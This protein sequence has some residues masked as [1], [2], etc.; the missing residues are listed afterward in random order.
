MIKD[1]GN[2]P[3]HGSYSHLY[4]HM[5]SYTRDTHIGYFEAKQRRR[6]GDLSQEGPKPFV[7][8]TGRIPNEWEERHVP[9]NPTPGT[10]MEYQERHVPIRYIPDT[11]G[12]MPQSS[13]DRPRHESHGQDKEEVMSNTNKKDATDKAAATDTEDKAKPQVEIEGDGTAAG[14][15]EMTVSETALGVAFIAVVAVGCYVIARA[16]VRT[17]SKGV[18]AI[19]RVVG[20]L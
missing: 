6:E 13:Y 1:A 2:S 17:V 12:C 3:Y 4:P 20:L 9:L 7:Y 19:G 10:V 8:V 16:G 14:A 11:G 15:E 5:S 18:K